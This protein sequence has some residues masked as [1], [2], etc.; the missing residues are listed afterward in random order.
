MKAA[1]VHDIKKELNELG[2]AQLVE[3][4]VRLAKYKADNKAL[5]HFLLFESHDKQAFIQ[6]IKQEMDAS[7]Q[8]LNIRDNL[9][10]AKKGLQKILRMTARY[11]RYMGDKQAEVELLLYFCNSL[12]N[13]GIPLHKNE[14]IRNMYQRQVEKIRKLVSAM[15]EDLQADYAAELES[16]G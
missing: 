1:S 8:E 5:L 7:F 10:F 2:K 11:C 12:K 13:K 3:L 4:C 9:Y 14:V 6:T 15:H 16:L